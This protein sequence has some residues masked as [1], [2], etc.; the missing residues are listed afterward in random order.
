MKHLPDLKHWVL[1]RE[2]IRIRK[3]AGEVRPY[4]GD[5]ILN[6]YRFCNVRREDDKVTRWIH[7]H[8][9]AKGIGHDNLVFATALARMVN[10]PETL[11]DIGFPVEW[12]PY[13]FIEAIAKRKTTGAKVWTSAYMI[14]GGYSAGGEAKEVIIARVL[15]KLYDQL[16]A[17][18]INKRDTLESADKKLVVPGIGTFL[19]GQIIAD[20]KMLDMPLQFAPDWD[21]WCG[22]GPG[23]TAGLN[24]LYDR[25]Q[26]AIGETQFRK[27]V[28]EVRKIIYA[29]TGMMLCA[30]NTQNVMCE[31]SKYVRTKYYGGKPKAR[32]TP[33][34]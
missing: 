28:N 26:K 22:V 5:V 33:A 27:E 15:S 13:S 18:P 10:L 14:T 31:F 12:A 16:V 4:T 34:P 23:S 32:Y 6:E 8:F 9:L 19:R 29:E 17:N 2:Y 11:A 1:E 24:Y 21:T 7:R 30:Q 20:L 3:E 25:P